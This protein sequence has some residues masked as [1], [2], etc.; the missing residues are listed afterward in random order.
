MPPA[1][2]TPPATVDLNADVGEGEDDRQLL[3]L[4]TTVH[5]ACGFHAGDPGVMHRTVSAAVAAGAVVGAHPSYP[6]SDGFGRR[7]MDRT[8]AQVAADLLYQVGALD[9]VARACGTRVRSVKPHGALY[10]RMAADEDCAWAVAEAVAAYGEG[11][12]LVAPAGSVAADVARRHG[13]P[14]V[15]EGFCD[16][17]YLPDGTLAPRASAGALVTD[18]DEAGRRAV[19]LAVSGRLVAVDGTELALRCD[20]LCVHGDT[21]GAAALAAAVR[22]ALEE[23]G[24]AL[25]AFS[26]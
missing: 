13:V 7:P 12:A 22:R 20:T 3:G 16:R 6:D 26:G 1:T 4:V 11:L 8:P 25:A 21:P 5:V 17:G 9:G 15:A 23:A 19:S 18:P 24:V 2:P 10:H 14:V